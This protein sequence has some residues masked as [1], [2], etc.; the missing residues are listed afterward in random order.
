MAFNFL[1]YWRD[2]RQQWVPLLVALLVSLASAV[3][4]WYVDDIEQERQ[5]QDARVALAA[6]LAVL[7]AKLEFHLNEPLARAKG[8]VAQIV[9]NDGITAEQ[10]ST[11]GDILLKDQAGV[12]NMVV[13][14]GLVIAMSY[15]LAGNEAVIGV[16]WRNV[17][18]QYEWVRKAIASRSPLLQGPV[19]L[20]QGGAGLILRSPVFL[21]DGDFYGMANIVLDM[22]AIFAAAGLSDPHMTFQVAI[23]GRDGLGANGEMIMGDEALF[24]ADPVLADVHLVQGSWHMAALPKGGWQA[25]V[26]Q[27]LRLRLMEILAFVTM[28]AIAFGAAF[29]IIGQARAEQ[30]L[31]R[32]STELERSNADLER[33]A[34][35]A[36][37]DL[38]T[39]LRNVGSYAQLLARRY[40][41]RLDEDA[42]DFIGFIVEGSNRMSR[43]INDLLDYARLSNSQQSLEMVDAQDALSQAL[44]NLT[45][46]ISSHGAIIEAAPLPK[47]RANFIQLTS[48]FQNLIDNAIKYARAE[49][50]PRVVISVDSDNPGWWRFR[51]SDNGIG[52]AAE[53]FDQIFVVFQ[54]LHVPGDRIGTGIGLA[55]CQR[56][57][58]HFGGRI[59]LE[60][61]PGQGTTFLFTLPMA[62]A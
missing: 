43:L 58:E 17:P 10:F 40:R 44:G 3:A 29:H 31:R 61:V 42:D 18:V 19:P 51:V 16:D 54:R 52:I 49:A 13:S 12:R 53:Y 22:G 20:I 21:R 55:I 14:H 11:I 26:G 33:F 30:A 1:K 8:V 36:S 34:Y 38:Q 47:V 9:A 45:L 37:H 60:S 50:L 23:R 27:A 4:L 46:T 62:E 24:F 39:P 6:R 59:W 32:K 2:W 57:V 25:V 56:I 35:I 48:L 7:R 5:I 15:P 28:T 41:G